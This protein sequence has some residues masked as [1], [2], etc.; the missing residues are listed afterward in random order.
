MSDILN[1]IEVDNSCRVVSI[2]ATIAEIEQFWKDHLGPVKEET[3][4]R[5][6]PGY[7]GQAASRT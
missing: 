3:Q 1:R 5:K 2:E 7:P 4:F 6:Q